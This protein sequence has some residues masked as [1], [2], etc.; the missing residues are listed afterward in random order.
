MPDQ[1]FTSGLRF[2]L[3]ACDLKRKWDVATMGSSATFDDWAVGV[4]LVNRFRFHA[5]GTQL[6]AAG[7][8]PILQAL[9]KPRTERL[10]LDLRAK[11]GLALED[12]VIRECVSMADRGIGEVLA[13]GQRAEDAS[14]LEQK[15]WVSANSAERVTHQVPADSEGGDVAESTLLGIMAGLPVDNPW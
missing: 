12:R 13:V 9:L 8:A 2:M 3:R 14:S 5:E 15:A 6:P 4:D 11:L 10:T 1:E 7:G